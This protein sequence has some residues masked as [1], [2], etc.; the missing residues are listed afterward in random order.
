MI[1]ENNYRDELLMKS[2]ELNQ[3]PEYNFDSGIVIK[4]WIWLIAWTFVYVAIAVGL[5]ELI[6]KDKR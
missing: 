5:L 3:K 2:A 4:C 6:D 1:E